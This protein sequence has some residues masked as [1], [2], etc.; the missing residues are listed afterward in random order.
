MNNDVL[1]P[2]CDKPGSEC[3]CRKFA[4]KNSNHFTDILG[5]FT[6]VDPNTRYGLIENTTD[7]MS[8]SEC[9]ST[10]L[11]AIGALLHLA[12]GTNVVLYFGNPK[13][14]KKDLRIEIPPEMEPEEAVDAILTILHDWSGG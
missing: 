10:A 13:R 11:S 3:T 9:E 12:V 8:E 5:E 6:S 7:Y 2:I 1:C 4:D 14:D